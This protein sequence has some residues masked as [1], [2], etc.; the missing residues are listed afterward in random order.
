MTGGTQTTIGAAVHRN[1]MTSAY[2]EKNL[3]ESLT[4]IERIFASLVG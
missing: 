3:K 1:A 4:V 2:G